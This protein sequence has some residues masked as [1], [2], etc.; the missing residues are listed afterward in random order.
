MMKLASKTEQS[1]P[2]VDLQTK[3]PWTDGVSRC[4]GAHEMGTV[5]T[6]SLPMQSTG[7]ACAAL[8]RVEG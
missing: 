7:A 2:V 4:C 3:I 1:K 8:R 6:S 5:V